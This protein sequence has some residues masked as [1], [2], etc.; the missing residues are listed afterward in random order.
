[1]TDPRPRDKYGAWLNTHPNGPGWCKRGHDTRVTGTYAG[2]DCAQ[3]SRDKAKARYA[4]G[5]GAKVAA[6]RAARA[7][8]ADPNIV[9]SDVEAMRERVRSTRCEH[10]DGAG[11]FKTAVGWLCLVHRNQ[12]L[13][14]LR[15]C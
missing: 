8:V 12:R 9:Q 15:A 13:T 11:E 3:C 7:V 10:C 14:A 5:R 6:R 4:A 1:M 2:G